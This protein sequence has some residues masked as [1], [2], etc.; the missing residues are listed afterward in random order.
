MIYSEK[1]DINDEGGKC[2]CKQHEFLPMNLASTMMLCVLKGRCG[3]VVL[4]T[5]GIIVV[6]SSPRH[7]GWER[8]WGYIFAGTRRIPYR[9]EGLR[10]NQTASRGGTRNMS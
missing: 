5:A 3:D 6:A 4:N 9:R 10:Q 7:H 8:G 1:N 2:H